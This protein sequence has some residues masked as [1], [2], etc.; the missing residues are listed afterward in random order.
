MDGYGLLRIGD[1]PSIDFSKCAGMEGVKFAHK[2][3]F[4]LKTTTRKID[5]RPFI[6]AALA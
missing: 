2:G 3:G 6:K 4:I 5:V 1:N